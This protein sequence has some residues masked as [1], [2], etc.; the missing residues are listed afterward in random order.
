MDAPV[1]MTESGQVDWTEIGKRIPT[2]QL[3]SAAPR[4]GAVCNS[5]KRWD[6]ARASDVALH[7]R[8]SMRPGTG[9]V[10]RPRQNRARKTNCRRIDPEPAWP[11]KFQPAIHDHDGCRTDEGRE[12]RDGDP[13]HGRNARGND[14]SSLPL[15]CLSNH[16]H[17]PCTSPWSG[18]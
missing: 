18:R 14:W 6:H 2:A 4:C 1:D 11:R 13:P 5:A 12:S 9:V 7:S 3:K 15:G 8:R 17:K 16:T 10:E